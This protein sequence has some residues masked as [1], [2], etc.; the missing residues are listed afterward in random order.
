MASSCVNTAS[1]GQSEQGLLQNQQDWGLILSAQ[2]LSILWPKAPQRSCS[3]GPSRCSARH[4]TPFQSSLFPALSG[5]GSGDHQDLA[6][7]QAPQGQTCCSPCSV[8]KDQSQEHCRAERSEPQL[9]P[10]S[11]SAG[12]SSRS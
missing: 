5:G 12:C 10:G 3:S 9:H 7:K 11:C 2:P 8:H 4:N 6:R 1:E